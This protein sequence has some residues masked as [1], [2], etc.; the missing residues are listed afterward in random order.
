MDITMMKYNI[1]IQKYKMYS[2]VCFLLAAKSIE[3][4]RRIPFISRL[5]R[6]V[7]LK[8]S[9]MEIRKAEIKVLEACDWN[10]LYTTPFEV[11]EFY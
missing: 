10:P 7:G 9:V 11:I 5:K 3:L 4:D 6:K 2:A 8:E 1:P